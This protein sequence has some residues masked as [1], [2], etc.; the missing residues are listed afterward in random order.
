MATRDPLVRRSKRKPQKGRRKSTVLMEQATIEAVSLAEIG[1]GNDLLRK[2]YNIN[3]SDGQFQYRLTKAKTLAGYAKGDGFR[4]AWREGRSQ[5]E[6]VVDAV[7]PEIRKDYI[8]RIL[9]L[10]EK[11]PVQTSPFNGKR[12]PTVDEAIEVLKKK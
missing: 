4:R 3:L 12:A 2:K 7:L 10:A 5:W 8:Q 11:P 9:P 6:E 1:K